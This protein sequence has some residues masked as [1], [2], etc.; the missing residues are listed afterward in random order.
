MMSVVVLSFTD[1]KLVVVIETF[2]PL[3]ASYSTGISCRR[4][5][6]C[7]YS[8]RSSVRL[9]QVSVLLKWLN[10]GSRKQRHTIVQDSSLLTPKTWAKLKRGH[11]QRRRQMQVD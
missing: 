5:S 9:S 10:V 2:Y 11:P 1:P 3:D 4:V 6:V 8:L 7:L